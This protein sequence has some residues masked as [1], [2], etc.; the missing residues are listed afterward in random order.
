MA[1]QSTSVAR[2]QC[3]HCSQ[4]TTWR[5]RHRHLDRCTSEARQ[6]WRKVRDLWE[7][8]CQYK[9]HPS[10]E[11]L[12]SMSSETK[13]M[14]T[15]STL[16][17]PS[18]CKDLGTLW[19]GVV[20]TNRDVWEHI[21]DNAELLAAEGTRCAELQEQSR[22]DD[23]DKITRD[24][25]GSLV[26]LL[27]Q[28]FHPQRWNW[29]RKCASTS[30]GLFGIA[31]NFR[32]LPFWS[33]HHDGTFDEANTCLTANIT[34]HGWRGQATVINACHRVQPFGICKAIWILYPPT[35]HNLRNCKSSDIVS[36]VYKLE[37]GLIVWTDKDTSLAIPVGTIYVRFSAESGIELERS[38]TSLECLSVNAR[39]ASS[40]SAPVAELFADPY[41][42]QFC[43]VVNSLEANTDIPT[44]SCILNSWLEFLPGLKSFL[45]DK[46]IDITH[47]ECLHESWAL[48]TSK[49]H[50]QKLFSCSTCKLDGLDVCH[51]C[52]VH[53]LQVPEIKAV[54]SS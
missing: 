27:E 16:E 24:R 32:T 4:V 9:P 51:F 35:P 46:T 6:L 42:D 31:C 3:P 54:K 45:K 25:H 20:P 15:Q 44:I 30:F 41:I 10:L 21:T 2:W 43:G 38:H 53:F 37:G 36:L 39:I 28:C 48:L 40:P 1:N 19:D 50:G 33:V 23:D 8:F 13:N 14:W 49:H 29:M 5:R 26:H 47:I 22:G 18:F 34:E 11:T 17:I 12:D 52:D 7:L